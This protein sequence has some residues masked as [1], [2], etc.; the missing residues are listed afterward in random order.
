MDLL[1]IAQALESGGPH[2]TAGICVVAVG[3]L[4]RA[5]VK[6]RD[7]ADQYARDIHAQLL[8]TMVELAEAGARQ[9]ASN[10]ALAARIENV[11]KRI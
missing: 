7:K 1:T 3:I 2:A 6:T 8:K 5:Y 10:N 4:A 9:A 11:E